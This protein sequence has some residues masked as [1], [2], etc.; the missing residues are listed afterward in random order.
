MV[1]YDAEAAANGAVRVSASKGLGPAERR[2][3]ILLQATYNGVL[4]RPSM[5]VRCPAEKRVLLE[6]LASIFGLVNGSVKVVYQQAPGVWV[7]LGAV[8]EMVTALEEQAGLNAM[9][10]HV[11]GEEQLHLPLLHALVCAIA[12]AQIVAL[13]AFLYY[14]VYVPQL[15]APWSFM[16]YLPLLLLGYHGYA[17]LTSLTEEYLIS[18]AMRVAFSRKDGWLVSLMLT[19]LLGPD[20][21]VLFCRLQLPPLGAS[22]SKAT[23]QLLVFWGFGLHLVLDAPALAINVLLHRRLDLEWDLYSKVLLATTAAS[24]SINFIWHIVRMWTVRPEEEMELGGLNFG[25][26]SNSIGTTPTKRRT[27]RKLDTSKYVGLNNPPIGN[28]GGGAL[29]E[30]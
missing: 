20:A 25:R 10:V 13:S 18:Q 16:I 30:A 29:Y 8:S 21:T 23:E 19:S 7:E 5:V 26:G 2:N 1:S 15:P 4:F 6:R 28:M 24:L 27:L 11:S 9:P 12:I 3:A 17:A 22:L 14:V